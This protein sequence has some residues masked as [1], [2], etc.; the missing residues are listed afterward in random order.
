MVFPSVLAFGVLALLAPAPNFLLFD[1]IPLETR[2]ELAALVLVGFGLVAGRSR[3]VLRGW[4][5]A[6]PLAV[7]R[8]AVGALAIG[9]LLH[10]VL[11]AAADDVGFAG[12]YESGLDTRLD[13]ERSYDNP[14]FR[15]GVTRIDPVL[16]FG[17][18][19]RGSR[20]AVQA[21]QTNWN[22]GFL[23]DA[24]LN[25]V[26][27]DVG[28]PDRQRLPFAVTWR[29]K[30][31][32]GGEL[33]IVMRYLGEGSL[34]IDGERTAMP[35]SYREP[36]RLEIRV[37]EGDHRL[38]LR[39]VFDDEFLIGDPPAG[40]YGTMM[41]GGGG[42]EGE[43]SPPLLRAEGA[44]LPFL[45]V[46]SLADLIALAFGGLVGA[47]L[48]CSL[49]SAWRVILATLAAL[50]VA[51][52]LDQGA[53]FLDPAV[54]SFD[55][56]VLVLAGL[57]AYLTARRP[58]DLALVGGLAAV[59]VAVLR[60][61][62]L[63][64]PWFTDWNVGA[65]HYRSPG[66][67]W[68]IY[69]SGARKI[70]STGSLQGGEDVFSF[71]PGFRYASFLAHLLL[72]DGDF[73]V[74]VLW[75]SLL[76]GSVFGS[77]AL[78][79]RGHRLTGPPLVMVTGAGLGLLA[80][81][82]SE[83]TL[84]HV[85]EGMAEVPTWALFP[86]AAP[87]LLMRARPRAWTV[88]GL[89][90]GACVF[91]RPNQLIPA[92]L[93]FLVFIALNIRRSPRAV[94]G[95]TALFGFV[96]A[97]PL[98]HNLYYGNEFVVFTGDASGHLTLTPIDLFR[99]PFD[100]EKATLFKDQFLGLL[101]LTPQFQRF[102]DFGLGVLALQVLSVAA[103]ARLVRDWRCSHWSDWATLAWPLLTF[104]SASMLTVFI[105]FPRHI[106]VVYA[107]AA[108]SVAIVEVARATRGVDLLGKQ[109]RRVDP[110][111]TRE[112]EV[113]GRRGPVGDRRPEA[114]EMTGQHLVEVDHPGQG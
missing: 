62:V 72:G 40:S 86:L 102:P 27:P 92:G 107:I 22:L 113:Q 24:R 23:N 51:A 6:A 12:C 41:V 3:A 5:D 34:T 98:I 28:Y 99:V 50:L 63:D 36:R 54:L 26:P 53:W 112:A 60:V 68:L 37:P 52:W 83:R 67:D 25:F 49:R 42:E 97:L 59:A 38:R 15:Q 100:G 85:F 56:P 114:G 18:L 109:E 78:I 30:F 93:L 65:V 74:T 79:L 47:A 101:Y 16:D 2:A 64:Y 95:V 48:A 66:D 8:G 89:A 19:Q 61:G 77:T 104:V 69:E 80:L 91:M 35:P 75:L 32:T 55:A 106:I 108:A 90:L 17:P 20:E 1:G 29:G 82:G 11:A 13:C 71:V 21:R 87:L 84:T 44:P 4:F 88:A 58:R 96:C 81:F 46:A 33:G 94:I 70:L 14:L 7:R 111:R 10:P 43:R 110:A 76:L 45:A 9:A 73:L 31:Q 103:A 39:Y 105:Y 57:F